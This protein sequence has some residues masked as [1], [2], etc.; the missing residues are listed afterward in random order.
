MSLMQEGWQH[1]RVDDLDDPAGAP[2]RNTTIARIAMAQTDT[3]GQLSWLL[4]NLV[5]G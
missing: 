2:V 5:S 4:D 1:G 3:A